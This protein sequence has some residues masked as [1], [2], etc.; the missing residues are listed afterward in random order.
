M[1]LVEIV[2]LVQGVLLTH[3]MNKN[4]AVNGHV[5]RDILKEMA[6]VNMAI[7]HVGL[8]NTQMEILVSI[9]QQSHPVPLTPTMALV[10]GAVTVG[11]IEKEIHA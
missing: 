7:N 9:V 5:I 11:I 4:E 3:T 1:S 6:Y 2:M 8:G 10:I